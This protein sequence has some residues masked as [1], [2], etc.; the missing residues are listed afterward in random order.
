MEL[1]GGDCVAHRHTN[2]ASKNASIVK[3]TQQIPL[4]TIRESIDDCPRRVRECVDTKWGH[5]E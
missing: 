4:K 1:S 5:F 2:L 3:V